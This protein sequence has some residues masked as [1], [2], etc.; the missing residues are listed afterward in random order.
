M[1]IITVNITKQIFD[2]AEHRNLLFKKR[3][4]NL[5]THRIDTEKQRMTGYLAEACV[6]SRF[7]TL[8]YSN[9][10]D[11]DFVFKS[12]TFDSKAQGCNSKPLPN[13]S[14]TLYEEQKKR[15]VNYYIF[16]RVKNDFSVAWICGIISKESFF[17]KAELKIAGTKNN[18]FIY[19]QS[20]YEIYYNKLSDITSTIEKLNHE[21]I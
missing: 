9:N 5:G 11:V 2:Q 8:S 13:Y 6:L 3:F 17:N 14:A 20:R 16:S 18:N 12:I 19:D 10:D 21:T 1:E 7:S 4:G 15:P